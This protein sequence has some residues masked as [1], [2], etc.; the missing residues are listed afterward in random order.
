MQVPI[1][2]A[3]QGKVAD[4]RQ[5]ATRTVQ[6]PGSIA[7]TPTIRINTDLARLQ[8]INDQQNQ[9]ASQIRS[10]DQQLHQSDQILG[11]MKRVLTDIIKYYPPYPAGEPERVKFLRSFSSMRKQIEQMTIPPEATWKGKMPGE[12]PPQTEALQAGSPSTNAPAAVVPGV[13]S[14]FNIADLP[15][16]ADNGQ[17]EATINQIDTAQA[18]IAGRRASLAEQA[19]SINHSEGYDAKVKEL[20]QASPEAWDLVLPAEHEAEKKSINAGSE[21]QQ[22]AIGITGTDMQPLLQSL[23]G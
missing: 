4:S 1:S 2:T 17:I 13:A 6:Q 20:N 19:P 12:T 22:A 21:L 11:Q 18:S 10:D 23:G 14:T 7:D 16:T 5:A 8:R 3:K 15:D 9:A